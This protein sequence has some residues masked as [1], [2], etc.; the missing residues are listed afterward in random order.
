[1][2]K[3][4]KQLKKELEECGKMPIFEIE[5]TDKDGAK[6]YI[7]CEIF[8]RGNSIIAQRDGVSTKERKSK[9][10]A[11]T[12]RVV[13]PSFSLDENLQELLSDIESDIEFGDLFS[14]NYN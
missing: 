9:F 10:I 6:D 13:D 12:K 5:V 7:V 3:Y 11:N 1:M 4:V 14:I 8:F 2:T